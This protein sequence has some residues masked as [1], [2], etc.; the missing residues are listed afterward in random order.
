MQTGVCYR[1]AKSRR[2]MNFEFWCRCMQDFECIFSSLVRASGGA[3]SCSVRCRW[4]WAFRRWGVVAMSELIKIGRSH[5]VRV[6]W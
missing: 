1:G 4:C 6:G 2:V 3:W 5:F